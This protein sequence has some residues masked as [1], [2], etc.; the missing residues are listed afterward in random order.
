MIVF[1]A[2]ALQI[3]GAVMVAAFVFLFLPRAR[4]VGNVCS[5]VNINSAARRQQPA[6]M[7]ARRASPR[8]RAQSD[9][10]E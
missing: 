8:V 2:Y 9:T 6:G 3:V 7:R 5:V 4:G 1:S 10:Q